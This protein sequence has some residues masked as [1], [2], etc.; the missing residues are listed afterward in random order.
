MTDLALRPWCARLRY[1]GLAPFIFGTALVPANAGE[2]ATRQS[3]IA[4][5]ATVIPA[6][7]EILELMGGSVVFH[8]QERDNE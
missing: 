3:V 7:F 6:G 4:E 8:P 5:A 2:E 1:P